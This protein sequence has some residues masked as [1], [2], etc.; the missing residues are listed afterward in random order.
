VV[1]FNLQNIW[2]QI[3]DFF[4]NV[5]ILLPQIWEK[6][7]ALCALRLDLPVISIILIVFGIFI[8]AFLIVI[9]VCG[10]RR[11]HKKTEEPIEESALSPEEINDE[12][13]QR[14]EEIV[15]AQ[16]QQMESMQVQLDESARIRHDFRQ[17]LLLLKEFALDGNR[18]AIE[19][20]LPQMRID[21]N[22]IDIPIC[23]NTLVNT[24]YKY[25][26][27]KA[28]A[29]GIEIDA[30]IEADETLWLSAADVGVLFGNLLENAVAAASEAAEDQRKLRIRTTQTTDCLVIAMGNTFGA[31]RVQ[32]ETGDFSSTKTAHK[33]I[34]LNSIQG[35]AKAYQGEAKF[36]LDKDLFMSYVILFR[37]ME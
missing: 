5:G 3:C 7:R 26:Y 24:I 34:G 16:A 29:S 23:K 33:G 35:I 17:E 25:Y 21:Q 10:A 36:V 12:R 18:Q 9:V 20:F 31:P 4:E 15:Q 19:Q 30:A 2:N 14:M 8:I 37:P 6:V 11:Q 32:S 28:I 27:A 13:F 22:V 1:Q